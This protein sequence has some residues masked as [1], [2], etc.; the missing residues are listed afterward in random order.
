VQKA[1]TVKVNYD[2]RLVKN[3]PA[4]HTIQW[5]FLFSSS[6]LHVFVKTC[7]WISGERLIN[8][9]PRESEWHNRLNV[10]VRR[11]ILSR[12]VHFAKAFLFPLHNTFP[13]MTLKTWKEVYFPPSSSLCESSALGACLF[14]LNGKLE[15]YKWKQKKYER[16]IFFFFSK[17]KKKKTARYTKNYFLV[18]D[19]HFR[20]I[21]SCCWSST[22]TVG[23]II[24]YYCWSLVIDTK[25]QV[26]QKWNFFVD[27]FFASSTWDWVCVS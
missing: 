25:L 26:S 18:I 13:N 17:A 15:G 2:P 9:A 27:F 19:L 7:V 23:V 1:K 22:V 20:R 11:K 16:V 8:K 5:H 4:R 6:T 3:F 21:V 12:C 10:F 14:F 24:T